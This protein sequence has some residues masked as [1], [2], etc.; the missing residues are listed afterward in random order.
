[1]SSE[2]FIIFNVATI[3]L[4]VLVGLLVLVLSRIKKPSLP[5]DYGNRLKLPSSSLTHD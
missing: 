5:P 3:A 4:S 2:T 1:M